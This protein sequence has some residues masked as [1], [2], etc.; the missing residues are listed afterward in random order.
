VALAVAVTIAIRTAPGEGTRPDLW[1]Y[2]FGWAIAALAG[3][4][5][6]RRAPPLGGYHQ[7]R[8][9]GATRWATTAAPGRG[10]ISGYLSSKR[11]RSPP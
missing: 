3:H 10:T 5:L 2:L 4:G 8:R 7:G 6:G 1:A 9:P 11:P